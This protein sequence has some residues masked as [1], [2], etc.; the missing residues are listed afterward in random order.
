M[1]RREHLTEHLDGYLKARDFED[2]GP[3]GLQ[4]EGAAEVRKAAFA[5]SATVE[6]AR[7]ARRLGAQAL[8]VHHGLFWDSAGARTITGAFAERVRPLVLGDVN[9][10]G[11][12]LPLDAHPEVGNAAGLAR[13]LGLSVD[14]PFGERRGSPLGVRGGLAEPEGAEAFR[15]RLAAV[16]DHPVVHA[17]P[18]GG[19]AVRTVGII[20]GGAG[21]LWTGARDLGLD[22]YVTGEVSEHQWHDAREGGVH[23]FAGGH[24]ATERFGVLALKEHL[25]RTFGLECAFI[26][27]RNPA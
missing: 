12:H 9:L 16:L 14:G 23:L 7:E 5:V 3:N 17:D 19:G 10:Y 1:V 15:D 21:G 4:V 24:H 26:D 2:Y 6:S 20:T 13:A 25:E 11:Y 18:E 27:S 8:V 22:A